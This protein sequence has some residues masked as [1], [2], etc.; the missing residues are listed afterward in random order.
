MIG[1]F[2]RWWFYVDYV[3]DGFVV[4]S[5]RDRAWQLGES[6][7]YRIGRSESGLFSYSEL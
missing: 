5:M 6:G 4:A 2:S 1:H 3:S 7:E